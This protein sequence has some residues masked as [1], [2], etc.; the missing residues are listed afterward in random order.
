MITFKKDH[1]YVPI[2]DVAVSNNWNK[3]VLKQSQDDNDLLPYI[4]PNTGMSN[5]GWTKIE[6]IFREAT[7]EEIKEYDEVGMPVGAHS[8]ISRKY[9]EHI[10]NFRDLLPD[11]FCVRCD[12][13]DPRWCD[14]IEILKELSES[15]LEGTDLDLYYGISGLNEFS[16]AHPSSTGMTLDEFFNLI[17][18]PKEVINYEIY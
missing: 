1:Y 7:P 9:P 4:C 6:K 8:I 3:W 18:T 2:N 14:Y 10:K 16:S 11:V 17:E 5:K 13:S 15:N 12:T